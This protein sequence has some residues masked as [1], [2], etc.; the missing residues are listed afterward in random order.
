MARG[1]GFFAELQYQNQLAAK[2]QEQATKAAYRA[3]L[4]AQR[5]AERAQTAAERA[6]LQHARADAAEQKAAEREA[7]RL[8]EES[9]KAEVAARNAE[10]ASV[11]DE[12]ESILSSTLERDD[13]VDLNSLRA[14]VERP[15]F[16]RQDLEIP[17]PSP[18][19]SAARPEPLFIAP[20]EPKGLGAVFGGRKKHD[21]LVAQRRAQFEA[22]YRA[23]Q[24]E[25]AALPGVHARQ[26]QEHADQEQQ[27][28]AALGE[29]R[30]QYAAECERREAE[31][32]ETNRRLDDL[33]SGIEYNVEDAIQQYVGIV[34]SNSVYPESF[35]VDYDYE[36]D[37]TLKELSL[38]VIVPS[39]ADLPAEKEYRYVKAK[40][41]I[42]STSLPKRDQKERYDNAVFRVALRSP[43]E[44]FEADRAGRIRTIALTVLAIGIDPA[45]GNEKRTTLVAAAAE[46][47][48]FLSFD[49]ANVVPRAT[50]E[51]LGALVSKSPFD[52]VEVDMSQGVRGG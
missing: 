11:N 16:P 39:P 46:R 1:R 10:L 21:E 47:E 45:T 19:L 41:V 22:A 36:F 20:E 4:A 27:R 42:A 15:P 44:I 30:S 34:L 14:V 43:H 13:Y 38:T 7:K 28:L 26:M 6:A 2:R 35:P 51:H 49:L 23:W 5:D 9:R 32:A 37:A 12:I 52:L 29:A 8:H 24:A 18:I 3:T 40:D 17:I 33:I 48:K 25:M 31:A 50:L